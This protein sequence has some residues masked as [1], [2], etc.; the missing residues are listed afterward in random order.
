M[1]FAANWKMNLTLMQSLALAAEYKALDIP[2]GHQ[3]II[4][5]SDLSLS[6]VSEIFN[7]QENTLVFSQDVSVFE[8][9]GSYTGEESAASVKAAG[10]NG[11]L[12]GHMERRTHL[13][14]ADSVI[15]RKVKGAL[16]AGIMV[17]LS[18]GETSAGLNEVQQVELVEEQLKADLAGIDPKMLQGKL[19][20]AFESVTTISSF[21]IQTGNALP[22]AGILNKVKL[23]R[24]WLQH[25]YPGVEFPII[26]GGSISPEN[27]SGFCGAA[28]DN[29]QKVGFDG[30]LIGKKSLD[31]AEFQ[32]LILAV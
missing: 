13:Q 8:N 26:Y 2:A 5:S 6:K 31:A 9:Y 12:I 27:I 32:K 19:M 28:G 16:N 1:I 22:V 4:L 14:E 21:G 20:V 30:F 18:V 11:C 24:A 17:I 15:N 23:I 25:N 29:D 7:G 3:V 10:G